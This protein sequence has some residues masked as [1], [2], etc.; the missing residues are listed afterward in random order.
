[1]F[2]NRGEGGWRTGMRGGKK[3]KRTGVEGGRCGA[4][5]VVSRGRQNQGNGGRKY[6]VTKEMEERDG[7]GGKE[8]GS[9][10]RFKI[11]KTKTKRE[12][13]RWFGGGKLTGEKQNGWEK[14]GE[15]IVQ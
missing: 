9:E 13:S 14:G 10:F 8:K 11:K 5:N 7:R 4:N 15:M 12:S 1:M 3:G 2:R 6:G